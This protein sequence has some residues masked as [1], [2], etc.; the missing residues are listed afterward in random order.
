MLDAI[1]ATVEQDETDEAF[2]RVA[3]ERWARVLETLETVARDDAKA[4]L[5]ARAR[6]DHP[7]RPA[8]RKAG[9]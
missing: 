5:K 8:P 4:W 3:D 2:H 1:T 7:P 9:G 6:G